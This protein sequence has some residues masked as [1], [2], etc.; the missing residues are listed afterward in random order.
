[1][2]HTIAMPALQFMRMG[3]QVAACAVIAMLALFDVSLLVA[4]EAPSVPSLRRVM[5]G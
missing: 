4:R 1:M 5:P 3:R 2:M